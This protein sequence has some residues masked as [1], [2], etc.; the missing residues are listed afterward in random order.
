VRE[1]FSF[2]ATPAGTYLIE[3]TGESGSLLACTAEE[4]GHF[5][6][7]GVGPQPQE[8]DAIFVPVKGARA[9]SLRVISGH[10]AAFITPKGSWQSHCQGPNC[11]E[12]DIRDILVE[13][14]TCSKQQTFEC[15]Q[16]EGEAIHIAVIETL[17]HQGW[18]AT[19]ANQRCPECQQ[20]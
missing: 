15:I 6:L 11:T 13:C 20:E 17:K 3:S 14:D 8:G 4:P 1:F 10:P 2:T 19:L 9:V 16:Y 7:K 18:R 5:I 12:F